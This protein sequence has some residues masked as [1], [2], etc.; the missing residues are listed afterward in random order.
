MGASARRWLV[1][2]IGC[3]LVAG[4]D[5]G[6]VTPSPTVPPASPTPSSVVPADALPFPAPAA[7]ALPARARAALQKVLDGYVAGAPRG[8][9]RGLTAAVVSARGGWSGAAGVDG[10]HR[11]IEPTSM[12]C[13]GSV[14]KT[15]VAAEAVHLAAEHRLDLDRPA[16]DY[17]DHPLLSGRP[18][19]RQLLSMTSGVPEVFTRTL[20]DRL[21]AD[22]GRTWTADQVLAYADLSPAAPGG[23]FVYTNTNFVLLGEIIAKVTGTG[24]QQAV[25][26]DLLAGDHG[27]I[28]VQT[29]ETPA[30]PLAGPDH[31]TGARTDGRYVPNLALASGVGAAGG[32]AADAPSLARWGYDLYGARLL[33]AAEVRQLTAPL[34]PGYGLGTAID[35]TLQG[36]PRLG[37]TGTIDGYSVSLIVLPKQQIAVTVFS[38]AQLDLDPFAERMLDGLAG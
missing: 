4:C 11:R 16:S 17:L 14:T 24:W 5:A 23:G 30:A 35:T 28:A 33:P 29:A 21:L 20:S 32:M 10:D 19:V 8:E 25:R 13:I 2:V 36:D 15:F 6:R 34:Q 26:R 27:R 22:P 9:A 31:S 1:L 7:A 3:V 18:T 38:P 37:H 12:M